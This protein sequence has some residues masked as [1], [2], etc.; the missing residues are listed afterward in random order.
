MH[1]SP[2]LFWRCANE[3]T[4]LA[5]TRCRGARWWWRVRRCS[6]ATAARATT[7][8]NSDRAA[9]WATTTT[10]T[11]TIQRRAPGGGDG[12][13]AAERHPFSYLPFGAGERA[14][15]GV[16]LPWCKCPLLSRLSQSR[17]PK[18]VQIAASSQQQ[19]QPEQ[20]SSR[21]L[22]GCPRQRRVPPAAASPSGADKESRWWIC[23]SRFPA[24]HHKT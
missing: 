3:D 15:L 4:S 22:V 7:S 24:I 5:G 23:A 21:A 6:A 1:A 19:Q 2:P 20:P 14:C 12:G 11:T 17:G 16:V 9:S 8:T 10:T 18:G 13:P